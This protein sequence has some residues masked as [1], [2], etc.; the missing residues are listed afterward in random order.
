MNA[1]GAPSP[2][3]FAIKNTKWQVFA[4]LT[5]NNQK[6]GCSRGRKMKLL[7]ALLRRVS[8]DVSVHFP[9]LR[10]ICRS[11]LG[12]LDGR[13]HFH[14]L[15]A[16]LPEWAVN[17]RTCAVIET[18]WSKRFCCGW[19]QARLWEFGRDAVSYV[20]KAS[21]EDVKK[22]PSFG[23]NGYE[24]SKFRDT[25]GRR[26]E[27]VLSKSLQALGVATRQDK[28]SVPNQDF[29]GLNCVPSPSVA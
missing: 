17:A 28:R 18:Y 4:T 9:R 14:V 22:S 19:A 29:K 2:D 8:K 15:I 24:V 21:S 26:C 6:I 5:W 23:G 20:L 13:H 7:F 10:W 1:S 27:V 16:G 25:D 12:E 11:E 3:F